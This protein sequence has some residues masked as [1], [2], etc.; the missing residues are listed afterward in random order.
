[1]DS[2]EPPGAPVPP[3]WEGIDHAYRRARRYSVAAFVLCLTA[4]GIAFGS[5]WVE[6][7]GTWEALAWWSAYALLM[8]AGATL[9]VRGVRLTRQATAD[10]VERLAV[11]L[12]QL[13][14]DGYLD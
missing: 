2:S 3:S 9:T 6:L 7:P 12:E 5:L 4:A 8:V 1:M 14:R 13:R 10:M 11:Q